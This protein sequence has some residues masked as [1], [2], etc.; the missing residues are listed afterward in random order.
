MYSGPGA[1]VDPRVPQNVTRTASVSRVILAAMPDGQLLEMRAVDE[2]G[3]EHGHAAGR[4]RDVARR[5]DATLE[6]RPLPEQSAR[7]VLGQTFAA[8]LDA[9]DP[10]EDE[11]NL[12]SGLSLL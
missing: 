5:A 10:V 3:L 11:E 8:A 9:Q 1:G 7:A 4:H 6:V 12:G 2:I